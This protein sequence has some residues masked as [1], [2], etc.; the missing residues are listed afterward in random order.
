MTNPRGLRPNE[1]RCNGGYGL[2]ENGRPVLVECG[3]Q[4]DFDDPESRDAGWSDHLRKCHGWG[5]NP[6]KPLDPE[7]L[8][9]VVRDVTRK[10]GGTLVVNGEIE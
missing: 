5:I 3:W 7:V 8:L 2:D 1:I 10:Y 6:P 4:R 9:E